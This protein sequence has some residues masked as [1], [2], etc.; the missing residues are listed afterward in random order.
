MDYN[1]LVGTFFQDLGGWNDAVVKLKME[2]ACIEEWTQKQK[3]EVQMD[4]NNVF[5]M[6]EFKEL[7]QQSV[8]V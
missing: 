4:I 1:Y 5:P 6:V 7:Q 2:V 3:A 8:F